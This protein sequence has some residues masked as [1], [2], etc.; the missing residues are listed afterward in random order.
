MFA[1]CR[2]AP[3][4]YVRKM[5]EVLFCFSSAVQFE[6]WNEE[7]EDNVNMIFLLVR[8]SVNEFVNERRVKSIVFACEEP[9]AP[10]ASSP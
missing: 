1:D 4:L 10:V 8:T 9:T 6:C 7:K 3:A 5:F 2:G